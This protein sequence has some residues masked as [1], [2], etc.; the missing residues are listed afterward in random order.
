MD[1]Q[2]HYF[3]RKYQKPKVTIDISVESQRKAVSHCSENLI[4]ALLLGNTISRPRLFTF[5]TIHIC[6]ALT[7][8]D[9]KLDYQPQLFSMIKVYHAILSTIFWLSFPTHHQTC[10][11]ITQVF[12]LGG[13]RTIIYSAI[14]T[15]GKHHCILW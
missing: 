3:D 5:L 9:C 12:V 1:K 8:K 2:E 15:S 13:N 7:T 10:F 11:F 14:C 6:N 4:C